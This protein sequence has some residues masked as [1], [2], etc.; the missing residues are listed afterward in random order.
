LLLPEEFTQNPTGF[1]YPLSPAPF[2]NGN[3]EVVDVLCNE[4]SSLQNKER[5]C[6][7]ATRM[8]STSAFKN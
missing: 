2:S 3:G 6:S 4:N 8:N 5:S 7:S 1:I